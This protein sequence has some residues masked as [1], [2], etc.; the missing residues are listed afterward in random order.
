MG[1]NRVTVLLDIDDVGVIQGYKVCNTNLDTIL[2]DPSLERLFSGKQQ[3]NCPFCNNAVELIMY[4][5]GLQV[6]SLN[7]QDNAEEMPENIAPKQSI[8]YNVIEAIENLP[9][10]NDFEL[11]DEIDFEDQYDEDV[12]ELKSNK[13]EEIDIK[14]HFRAV[15]IVKE[16]IALANEEF[17]CEN[18][19]ECFMYKAALISHE[20]KC[21]NRIQTSKSVPVQDDNGFFCS[22]CLQKFKSKA[23]LVMHEK[24]CQG[25]TVP[26]CTECQTEYKSQLALNKHIRAVHQPIL[27]RCEECGDV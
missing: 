8:Q 11:A 27:Y 15:R 19:K 4:L 9:V 12:V 26:F 20:K 17:K 13:V 23:G 24:S 1:L 5:S 16:Q 22:K 18:C 6:E 10:D 3:F 25:N 21:L 7:E 14:Q 2:E